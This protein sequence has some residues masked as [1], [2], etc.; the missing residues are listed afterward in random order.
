[1]KAIKMIALAALLP[2]AA[3]ADTITAEY[4]N[5]TLAPLTEAVMKGRQNGVSLGEMMKIAGDSESMQSIVMAAFKQSAYNTE[6]V[7]DKVIR[8]FRD[9][10]HLA[11]L[12]LARRNKQ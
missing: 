12:Q 1:M 2:L 8:D 9:E 10:W 6:S 7:K 4:C 3:Q 11:C 5:D